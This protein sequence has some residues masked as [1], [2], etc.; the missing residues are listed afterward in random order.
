MFACAIF[1]LDGTLIDSRLDITD[2]FHV[3]ADAAQLRRPAVETIAP[4][5]GLPLAD[6]FLALW[7]DL[8]E[9]QIETLSVAYRAYYR[10]NLANRTLP[11]PGAQEMLMSLRPMRLGI[12]TTKRT[13][14]AELAMQKVGLLPLVDHVQGTDDFPAKPA[15]DVLLRAAGALSMPPRGCIYCG[16]GTWDIEAARRANMTPIGVAHGGTR[17]QLL[18]EAGA[19]RVVESLTDLGDAIRELYQSTI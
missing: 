9:A 18:R 19:L 17:A 8:D 16:D 12:A 10:E 11:Y 13:W 2:A 5:I 7:G 6:M 4:Y 3:A 15:P 14:M 1:D